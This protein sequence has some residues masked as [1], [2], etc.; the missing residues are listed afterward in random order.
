[1]D[2]SLDLIQ[3]NPAP[4][5]LSRLTDS[6]SLALPCCQHLTTVNITFLVPILDSFYIPSLRRS[7]TTRR[8][9]FTP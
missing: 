5:P 3:P 2:P 4:L 8:L 9:P 1:M 7:L 6:T